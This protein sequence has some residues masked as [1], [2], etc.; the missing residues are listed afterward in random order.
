MYPVA[1]IKRFESINSII[2]RLACRFSGF[3]DFSEVKGFV[4]NLIKETTF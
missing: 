4:L 3:Y 2:R 1:N